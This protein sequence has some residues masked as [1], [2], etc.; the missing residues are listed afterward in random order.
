MLRETAISLQ[1]HTNK[2]VHCSSAHSFPIVTNIMHYIDADIGWHSEM[3]GGADDIR[4]QCFQLFF[5]YD[6]SADV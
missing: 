2:K 1:T 3:E 5:Q 6:S 4:K